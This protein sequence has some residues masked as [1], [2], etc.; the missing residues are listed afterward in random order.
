MAKRA[1]KYGF[2]F[3]MAILYFS[4]L[5]LAH[6]EE[7]GCE[8]RCK[9]VITGDS[10]VTRSYPICFFNERLPETEFEETRESIRDF[11]RPYMPQGILDVGFTS[12]LRWVSI[13]GMQKGHSALKKVWPRVGCIGSYISSSEYVSYRRCV[14]YLREF[15]DQSK[16]EFMGKKNDGDDISGQLYCDGK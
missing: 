4:G 12:D 14:V 8:D 7:S 6:G 1:A 2:V 10:V 5:N 11:V 13:K 15:L 16:Y 3:L 9:K